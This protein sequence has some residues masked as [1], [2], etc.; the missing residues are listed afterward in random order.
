MAGIL[1]NPPLNF[2]EVT[3]MSRMTIGECKKAA[4]RLL[5][6]YSIAGTPVPLSYNDQADDIARMLDLINDAQMEIAKTNKPIEETISFKIPKVEP[7]TP[8]SSI[9][10]QM[11]EEFWYPLSITF[12]PADGGDKRTVH[13]NQFD[14]IGDETLL[15]PNKP[16]GTYTVLYSRYPVRYDA[17]TSD[18]TELDNKP[19]TH[20]IIPYYVAAMI[21][22]DQNP[23]QYYYLYNR[24]E[25]G[26]ARLSNRPAFATITEVDDAYG[27]NNFRGIR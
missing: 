24:W 12:I 18:N 25:T 2:Y 15:L 14:W 1:Y 4:L 17:S 9:S 26:L 5:N 20:V 6:Q 22:Q 27:F 3:N 23:K 7:G 8:S 16:A 13:A 19:D 11:P 21:A 10:Y